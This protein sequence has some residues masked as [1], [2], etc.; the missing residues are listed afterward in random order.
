M[1]AQLAEPGEQQ[2]QG[3]KV[4]VLRGVL[5]RD[6]ATMALDFLLLHCYTFILA[7]AWL[8]GESE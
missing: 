6:I 4:A 2:G 8:M 3:G 5:T 1:E 7:V